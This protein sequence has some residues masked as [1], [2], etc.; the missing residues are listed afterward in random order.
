MVIESGFLWMEYGG[1]WGWWWEIVFGF[2]MGWYVQYGMWVGQ[3][4]MLVMVI[5]FGIGGSSIIGIREYFLYYQFG[6]LGN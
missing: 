6:F 3:Q 5:E 2:Y 1:R 4:G